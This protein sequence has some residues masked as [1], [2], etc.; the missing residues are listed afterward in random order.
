MA[1]TVDSD[2]R[3]ANIG[4]DGYTTIRSAILRRKRRD[5]SL[6]EDNEHK[7]GVF[8]VRGTSD[9]AVDIEPCEGD[10]LRQQYPMGAAVG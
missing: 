3:I 6:E 2:S 7:S 4:H 10:H 8:P 1:A 9:G 5:V